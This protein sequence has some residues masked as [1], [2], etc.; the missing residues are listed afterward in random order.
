LGT[1]P[2]QFSEGPLDAGDGRM[3][4][5]YFA[6]GLLYGA[7]DTGVQVNGALQAGIAWFLVDPGSSPIASTVAHQGYVGVAGQNVTYPAIAALPNGT[8]AMAYTLTGPAHYPS[9]AYS[10][11]GTGGVTGAVHIAAAGVGPQDGFTEYFPA[12]DIGTPPRPR[13]GDY[14]AAVA[15]GS[16]IWLASEYIAQSCSF[17]TYQRDMTCGN[18]RAPLIN[19]ATRISAVGP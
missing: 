13:W 18:T 17:A 19:W 6:H 10:L 14:G 11:V 12:G 8:G 1:G 9:A 4:Q 16:T 7:L 5:V 3:L 15:A 2:G